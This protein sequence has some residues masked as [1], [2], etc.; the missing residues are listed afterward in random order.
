MIC[1]PTLPFIAVTTVLSLP[2]LLIAG[3]VI[4]LAFRNHWAITITKN[5]PATSMESDV[6]YPDT[7][8]YPMRDRSKDR[9]P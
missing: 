5:R 7:A 8:L 4:A 6:L 9:T 1:I 2:W 3:F